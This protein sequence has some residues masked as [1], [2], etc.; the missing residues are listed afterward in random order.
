MIA[1][2]VDPAQAKEAVASQAAEIAG[3]IKPPLVP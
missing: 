3:M 1:Q 2:G